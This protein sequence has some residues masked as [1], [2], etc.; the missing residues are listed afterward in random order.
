MK[1]RN[2]KI[3]CKDEDLN[4]KN[5]IYKLTFPN[6]KVYIGQTTLKLK[7]RIRHHYN[8]AFSNNL[9]ISST[10]KARA[11]HKYKEFKVEVLYQ[12]EDLD[13]NEIEYIKYYNATN[14]EF[15]YN[16]QSGGHLNKTHSEETKKKISLANTGNKHTKETKELISNSHKGKNNPKATSI[17]IIDLITNLQYEF[18]TVKDAT[19]F[20]NV[21]RNVIS[22]VLRGKAKTFKNKQYTAIYKEKETICD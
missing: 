17:I 20:Y 19:E 9:T 7:Y 5:I 13:Y 14:R 15:G 16:L 21:S 3:A 6:G 1:Y 12:G 8:D 2:I 22:E 10:L 11:I 18:N 4:K